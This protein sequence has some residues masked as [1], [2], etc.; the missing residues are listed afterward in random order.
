MLDNPKA[1]AHIA[2]D[3]SADHFKVLIQLIM[4]CNAMH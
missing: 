1:A 4:Q 2:V 3:F